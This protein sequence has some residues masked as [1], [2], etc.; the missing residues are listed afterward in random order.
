MFS[1][2]FMIFSAK[3]VL[4]DGNSIPKYVQIQVNFSNIFCDIFSP[5][6]LMEDNYI[7]KYVQ[8]WRKCF[9]EIIFRFRGLGN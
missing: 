5:I 3:L 8:M 4:M 9:T 2:H 1:T 6:F 7:P